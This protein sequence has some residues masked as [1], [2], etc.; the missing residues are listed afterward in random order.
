MTE[1]NCEYICL[2]IQ[3]PNVTLITKSKPVQ[4]FGKDTKS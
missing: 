1:L 4:I 3:Y 2:K